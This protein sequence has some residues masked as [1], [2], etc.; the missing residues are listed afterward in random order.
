[1]DPN[2]LMLLTSVFVPTAFA[3]TFNVQKDA[4]WTDSEDPDPPQASAVLT[5]YWTLA[6]F[7]TLGAAA[8]LALLGYVAFASAQEERQQILQG[9]K[10]LVAGQKMLI[11]SLTALAVRQ[12]NSRDGQPA[13]QTSTTSPPAPRPL[14]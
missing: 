13:P 2:F 9:Y 11:E 3:Q 6:N 4:I 12:M 5:Q 1:K 10:E 8:L 14:P 7:T